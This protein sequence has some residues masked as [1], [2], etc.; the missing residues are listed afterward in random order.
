MPCATVCPFLD[1]VAVM[2]SPSQV[3][4]VLRYNITFSFRIL[5]SFLDLLRIPISPS[6]VDIVLRI[7]FEFI[8]EQK[9]Q[10][11]SQFN[12]RF[13]HRTLSLLN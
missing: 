13:S 8:T 10:N 11:C 6:Q 7:I 4:I 9:V 2:I 3:D 5:I 12:L 1:V